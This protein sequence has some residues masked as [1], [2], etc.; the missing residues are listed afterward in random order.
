VE[1][2]LFESL[3]A[4]ELN[5]MLPLLGSVTADAGALVVRSGTAAGEVYL[6]TAGELSVL[7]E[8]GKPGGHRLT[9]LSAGMTFGEVAFVERG[10]RSADVRADTAVECR[11]LSYATLDALAV[12]DPVLHGK[13]LRNLLRVVVASLRVA[14]AEVAYLT[15]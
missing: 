14:N 12:S 10:V 5:R 1:H 8:N 2:E 15:R 13:L 9:T 4:D 3:T 7:S 6:V 11:T